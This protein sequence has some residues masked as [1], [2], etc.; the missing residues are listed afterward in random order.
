[1]T[2]PY[3]TTCPHCGVVHTAATVLLD[4]DGKPIPEDGNYSFCADCGEFSMFEGGK[5]RHLNKEEKTISEFNIGLIFLKDTWHAV[6]KEREN[7][8]PHG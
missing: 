7:G 5:L 1:M 4:T 6:M 3:I 8:N 2:E